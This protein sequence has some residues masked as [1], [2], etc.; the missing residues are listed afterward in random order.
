MATIS[1]VDFCMKNRALFQELDKIGVKFNADGRKC[2]L[3]SGEVYKSCYE[4]GDG[5]PYLGFGNDFMIGM[6]IEYF[7]GC[8]DSQFNYQFMKI[9]TEN[10]FFESDYDFEAKP[11]DENG[12][13]DRDFYKQFHMTKKLTDFDSSIENAYVEGVEYD[14]EVTAFRII[15]SDGVMT[16]CDLQFE[17]EEDEFCDLDDFWAMMDE[18]FEDDGFATQKI[19]QDGHWVEQ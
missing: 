13:Y 15:V 18:D 12:Y 5:I 10:G 7:L 8:G 3:M 14:G 17:V 11:F 4:D 9:L 1:Y 6:Y 16:I 2:K 19:L